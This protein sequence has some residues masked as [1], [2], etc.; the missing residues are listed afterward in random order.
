M[1]LTAP[2]DD[3]N[4]LFMPRQIVCVV[5]AVALVYSV[6]GAKIVL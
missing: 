5:A 6:Q 1:K 3:S 4:V 2:G